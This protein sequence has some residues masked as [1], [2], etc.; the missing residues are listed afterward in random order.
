MDSSASQLCSHLDLG[1]SKHLDAC[2]ALL[3]ELGF[4]G[5]LS[6]NLAVADALCCSR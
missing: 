1:L 4:D 3:L 6:H 5:N 2:C